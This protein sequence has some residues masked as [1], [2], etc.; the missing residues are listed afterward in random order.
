[1]LLAEVDGGTGQLRTQ[2]L[3]MVRPH[4]LGAGVCH[5]QVGSGADYSG[6]HRQGMFKFQPH[7]AV[8][9]IHQEVT[10]RLHFGINRVRAPQSRCGCAG[11]ADLFYQN[12]FL[13]Q[14]IQ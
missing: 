14:I 1:M 13:L 4:A 2:N 8:G 6:Q 3:P 12:A 9:A 11:A 5:N 7:L 10:T